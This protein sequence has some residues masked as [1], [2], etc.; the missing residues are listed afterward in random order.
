VVFKLIKVLTFCN[1]NLRQNCYIVYSSDNFAVLIDPGGGASEIINLI[2]SNCLIPLAILNTHAHYDHIGA[3]SELTIKY[4]IPFYLHGLDNALLRQANIY[5]YV[6][7]GKKNI[8]IPSPTHDLSLS[9]G[10]LSIGSINIGILYTPGHTQGGV[11]FLI[12][13]NLFSGDTL[14]LHGLGRSD[15]PGGNAK[16]LA[17]SVDSLMKLPGEILVWPGHGKSFSLSSL[18]NAQK[19]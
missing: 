17:K 3:I 2:A 18:S 16:L 10:S 14:M 6:F 13:N 8:D 11:S 4:K 5:R 15:F 9:E 19:T 7:S 12:D 1:G